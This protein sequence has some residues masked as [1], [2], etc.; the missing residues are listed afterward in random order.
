MTDVQILVTG[1]SGFVGGHCI[2]AL[3]NAGSRVRT[4]IRSPE[5]ESDVRRILAAGG[6][7]RR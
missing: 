3:L 7:T 6:G 4:T 2:I 5:R 1:C